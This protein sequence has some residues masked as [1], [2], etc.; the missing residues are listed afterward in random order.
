MY[1]KT[2]QFSSASRIAV[3]V[4]AVLLASCVKPSYKI[5]GTVSGLTGTGLV[6][7]NNGGDNLAISAN[8]AFTFSTQLKK[9]ESYNVTVFAQ[10]SGQTCT[11]T[12]GTGTAKGNVTNVAVACAGGGFTVGGSVTGLTGT[13]LVL[14]NN[15]GSD[16]AI[17]A[18]GAFTFPGVL[19]NA[20]TYAVTVRTPPTGQGCA[21][22]NGSGT[23]AGANVTNVAVTCAAAPSAPN[24]NAIGFGVKEL[25][26][27]WTAVSGAT[28]YRLLESPDGGPVFNTVATNITGLSFNYTIP[29]HRRLNA[30][31]EVAA[32]NVGGCT[33]ST[34]QDV[35]AGLAQ[36]I[37]YMK[38]SNTQGADNFGLAVAL[39]GDGLTLA[40]GASSEDSGSTGI[41]S[42]PDE[43]ASGA[44]AVY[45]F[46]RVSGAWVQQAYVKASNAG[47]GDNFGFAISLSDDGNTLAVGAQGESSSVGGINSVPDEAALSSGAAY[48]F[49]RSAGTW[50]EQA[51]VKASNPDMADSFGSAV[52]LSGDGNTLA[53]GAP[54][55]ASAL[56]GVT[57]GS[58][59]EAT[60]GNAASNSGAVYVFARNAASWSQQAYVKASNTD[61]PDFFGNAV[62]LSGDGNTLAVGAP[63]EGSALTGVTAGTVSEAMTGNGAPFSGA[64][65]VFA[66]NAGSWSQQAYVKA[67]NTGGSDMFGSSVSLSGDGNTLAAGAPGE[68]S[69]STG[70]DSTPDEAAAGA[71]AAY[72]YTRSAGTWTQQAYVKASNT[73]ASDDFGTSVAL[74]KDGNALAV[75][76]PREDG[77]G[78]GI[79]PSSDEGAA[80][81]GA[82][83]FYSRSAGV[84]AQQ[85]YV[86]A[87]NTQSEDR[88]GRSV[89]L[90]G[91]GN[92][93]AVGAIG[94]DSDSTGINGPQGNN[95]SPQSGAAYLY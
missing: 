54:S 24:V 42:V 9:D 48:V 88:F 58:V 17:S 18:S 29:V 6:L 20:A 39:S 70:I 33:A 1:A 65:Y 76:A 5:G 45:V 8:G 69:S 53:V 37:G 44:G 71:G 82:V 78:T 7:R 47:S 10:P 81:S 43:S 63:F 62:A 30:L 72:V 35:A 14:Q 68:A 25:Q 21:V 85:S 60:A 2:L 23:I 92:T 13:G 80:N 61:S 57:A 28:S 46:S 32:C 11:V 4:L 86:K 12:N 75:G 56:T 15:G 83:Y 95:N 73:E 77:S 66:R 50:T 55:E 59:S 89:T 41:N 16:L 40:I 22:A 31:Y 26:F 51:Y 79:E 3:L 91:D 52:A 93:L 49:V 90:S 67:S 87:T 27:S 84:W 34:S 64:V 38:A 36:A 19:A 94:E 74:S